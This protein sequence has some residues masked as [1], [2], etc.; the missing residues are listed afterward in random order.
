MSESQLEIT[1]VVP[2]YNEV[3]S[4][5]PLYREIMDALIHVP[6]HEILFIND[7]STDGS[8]EVLKRIAGVD[9][10][11]RV[12][13]FRR[14]FGKSAALEAAFRR[15]RGQFVATLDADLQ[16]DPAEIVP[17]MEQMKKENLDLVSGWKQVRKDPLSKKIPSKLFNFATRICSGLK[18][19]D[20][21][22]GL[23]VY[24]R[25]VTG[26]IRIHGELHR[27]IPAIAHWSGFRVGERP[28]N[29]RERR[30]GTTKF[31]PSRFL[32]GFLDLLTVMF[33]RRYVSSPLHFFGL[34]GGA[35]FLA[36]AVINVYL[37]I[38]KIQGNA[39]G[40]R[41]LLILAVMLVIVGI[42]F[43]SFGL[44]GEMMAREPKEGETYQI[45]SCW[46]DDR[47]AC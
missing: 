38:E 14:N 27:Y 30:F 22:C 43:I 11:V 24:R 3:E 7:G 17:M 10:K 23:K 12:V 32:H 6:D 15:A 28:V 33:L 29:H 41:P 8:R 1:V 47:G 20:F 44:L 9:R 40:G 19:H 5:E 45:E 21:N 26:A 13:N 2:L 37:L 4:L 25:E 18:L 36:G 34:V 46:P 16:D 42:Q 31:G 35:V 39:I